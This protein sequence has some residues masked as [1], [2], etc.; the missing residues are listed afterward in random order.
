MRKCLQFVFCLEII[1]F[2]AG[3]AAKCQTI[4]HENLP[5]IQFGAGIYDI[6]R[7]NATSELQIEVFFPTKLSFIRPMAS[8]MA[9]GKRD[10]FASIGTGIPIRLSNTFVFLPSLCGGIYQ[11]GSGTELG[12]AME[13]RSNLEI[14]YEL[15]N[16]SYIGIGVYHFSNGSLSKTNPG[17]ESLLLSYSFLP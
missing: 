9:S 3:N 6:R 16:H 12:Y 2:F 1:V 11:H 5:V 4:V 14:T 7:S 13:F 15:T 8:V 17:L 10:M